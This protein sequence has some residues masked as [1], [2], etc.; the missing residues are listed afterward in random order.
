LKQLEQN[1]RTGELKV[2]EVPVPCASDGSVLV[3]TRVSL[4]SSGTERQLVELAKASLAGKALARPDLVQQMVRKARCEGLVPTLA[5]A[6]AKLDTPIPL[7]YS[8][9]GVVLEAGRR[10]TGLESGDRVACAGAGYANHAEVNA[11]PK[12]LCVRVPEGVD[13]EEASFV[14]VGAIALQGVRLMAPTLGERVVVLGLGLIG[15]LTVQ[16]LKANGC[17][18]LGF[19]PEP[20]RAALARDLGADLSFTGRYGADA[21]IVTAS[22]PSSE[23][24]N[25]AAE[26][27]RMK[28]RVVVVGS[29]GMNIERD[30]FYKRELDLR[31]AMS[32]GPGRHDPAYEVAGHDY[33]FAYVRWTEQRNMQAF[34][35]L[36]ADRRVTPKA[37]VTHRF[38]IGEAERAYA[39]IGSGEPHLAV[40]LTYPANG[41][42]AIKR[43]IVLAPPANVQARE[44]VTRVGFVGCG[45]YAKSVLLPAL[46]KVGGI[47][48]AGVATSTAISARHAAERH[49]FAYAATDASEVIADSGADTVF[50]ATRHNSHARY[51]VAALEAGKHVF[52][53]KPLA[54]D[55]EELESVLAAAERAPGRLAVGFNRRF[56]P[57]MRQAKAALQARSS[58]LVMLYRINAGAVAR[59]SWL[60]GAEGG[61]R[62]IGEACHFVD[63]LTYLCGAHPVEVQAVAAS[64]HPDAVSILVRF[65][66]GSTGRSSTRPL[67]TAPWARNTSK[68]SRTAAPSCSTIS[69]G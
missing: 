56:A 52:C 63:A 11:I 7:G 27:S 62:I 23:P 42:P 53:E 28:G 21:V 44:G 43:R 67:G 20:L 50:I 55:R 38:P 35:E 69:A 34:L 31:V 47:S 2:T 6:L 17:R 60:V 24:V 30:A 48:L 14:T 59:D 8:L 5:K 36:V 9:S 57:L 39:L 25:T 33:P 61:G 13:D 12:N 45:N 1:Y 54:L 15:Q 19:D 40:L 68:C 41:A 49:G 51:I 4:I 16:L 18:V 22:T 58:S 32:Y 26:I 3:A 10:V 37:V 29:V 65:A 66:D 46:K 64:A